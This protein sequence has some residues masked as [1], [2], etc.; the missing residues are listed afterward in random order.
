MSFKYR[1]L[2]SIKSNNKSTSYLYPFI[3]YFSDLL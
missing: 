1:Q 3:L 2:I